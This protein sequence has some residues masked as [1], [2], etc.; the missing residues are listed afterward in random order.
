MIGEDAAVSSI[1]DGDDADGEPAGKG[2]IERWVDSEG[3][4]HVELERP[5]GSGQGDTM[6]VTLA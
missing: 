5:L 3:P 6:S 2:G 1:M 4:E